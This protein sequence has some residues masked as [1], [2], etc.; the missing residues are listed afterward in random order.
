MSTT[1]QFEKKG[2]RDNEYTQLFLGILLQIRKKW[3]GSYK[4]QQI[5]VFV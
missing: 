2:S 1:P 5:T 3:V 4:G